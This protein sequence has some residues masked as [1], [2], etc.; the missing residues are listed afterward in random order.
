MKANNILRV[1]TIFRTNSMINNNNN[2]SIPEEKHYVIF[3]IEYSG[4]LAMMYLIRRKVDRLT[5]FNTFIYYLIKKIR[6]KD[7]FKIMIAD[8]DDYMEGN[9]LL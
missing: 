4:Y 8:A 2:E 6:N 1:H 5:K 7:E 9:S 3:E